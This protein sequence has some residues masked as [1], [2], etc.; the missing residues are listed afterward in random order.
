MDFIIT[1]NSPG[2][3][4]GW[5]KP[6]IKELKC[7]FPEA[8]ISVFL[9]PCVFASGSEKKVLQE[10]AETDR[11]YD[12]KE[13]LKYILLKVKPDGF[14]TGESGAVI[15]LGG[16]L[17]H[18]VL[19][20]KKL[21]YPVIAYTEGVFNWEK[22]I[23]SFLVPDERTRDV[24]LKKG[25]DTVKVEVIGNLMFDA[26]KPELSTKEFRAFSGTERETVISLFPGSRPAELEYMLPFFLDTLR[27][28]GKAKI[29]DDNQ[30]ASFFLSLSPFIEREQ[31][32]KVYESYL[33]DRGIKGR[34]LSSSKFDRLQLEDQVE[35]SVI[36][37]Q[38][39][40]LM[41]IS[42][43]ALTIPGTNNL[44]LAH[45]GV[46]MLVLLPLNRPEIIPLEGI[47]GLL[48]KVPLL[49]KALKR[50]LVPQIAD[51]MEYVSLVNIIAG[52]EL[53]PELR[54]IL[55]PA[56]LIKE[57][58]LLLNDSRRLNDM[59][60]KLKELAG[61]KGAASRLVKKIGQSLSSY[62]QNKP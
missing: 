27:E 14:N 41:Q 48:G 13:Y 17:F 62:H 20:G 15:F 8:G 10:Y 50:R 60:V 51:Q 53:V 29:I 24:L 1:A 56:D 25:A 45:F 6:V 58:N 18:A 12:G 23:E 61:D 16:D 36:H 55:K 34:Y 22:S 28:T 47:P 57:M 42:D 54:G 7:T 21:S 35:L 19:L 33:F 44:E 38:Q 52:E 9:T 49:G 5:V 43:L 26:L 11:V 2:E 30:E 37:N 31:L 32:Q 46:P 39:Y 59:R 4:A 3:V 40:S